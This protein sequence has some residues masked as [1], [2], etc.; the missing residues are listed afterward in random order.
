MNGAIGVGGEQR[1]EL[2]SRAQVEEWLKENGLVL[3]VLSNQLQAPPEDDGRRRELQLAE[4]DG[5]P[6]VP[7]YNGDHDGI[8]PRRSGVFVPN[9]VFDE[10]QADLHNEVS[11]VRRLSSWPI[12]RAFVYLDISDFSK[13]PTGVQLLV[14]QALVKISVQAESDVSGKAEAKL[15]IGDGYI[16]VWDEAVG[17]TRFAGYL[18][19]EIEMAVGEK[20]APEFHFRIGVHI[21]LVRCFW[22]P[23]R[24]GWN[25]V[26]DGI[27][28]GNRVLSAIGKE[29]DDVVFVS[30]QVRSKLL[31]SP[32]LVI[33][34]N[35]HNR[36][37]K[38]DKHGRYWR[39]YEYNHSAGY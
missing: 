6:S 5:A 11:S 35:L 15:C 16:Y 1:L 27:N 2:D 12:V 23:G 8:G 30:G 9:E 29:T 3:W 39:V 34:P 19:R 21:G 32:G 4:S 24:N 18:A 36:G 22:D 10:M 38:A 25:Y 13:L 31:S 7:K 37:R 26:G 14:I 28:G 33:V 17:A 20:R